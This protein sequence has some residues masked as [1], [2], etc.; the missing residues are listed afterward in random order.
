MLFRSPGDVLGVLPHQLRV[1]RLPLDGGHLVLLSCD[2]RGGLRVV[3]SQARSAESSGLLEESP[4]R[5]AD[6]AQDR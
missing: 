5:W 2:E 4:E 6:G 3:G 1:A